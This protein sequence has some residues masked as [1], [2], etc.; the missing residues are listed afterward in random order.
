MSS[1]ELESSESS[2]ED[3]SDKS[4]VLCLRHFFLFLLLFLSCSESDNDDKSDESCGGGSESEFTLV[5]AFR[6][7]MLKYVLIKSFLFES[8]YHQYFCAP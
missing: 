5:C 6:T 4:S 3:A 2:L 8:E 7:S 1:D